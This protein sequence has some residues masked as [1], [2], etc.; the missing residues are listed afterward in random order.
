MKVGSKCGR[1]R[2]AIAWTL[3]LGVDIQKSLQEERRGREK[4]KE[5]VEGIVGRTGI[6]VVAYRSAERG[7]TYDT[8]KG[9]DGGWSQSSGLARA[10]DCAPSPESVSQRQAGTTTEWC[11]LVWSGMVWYCLVRYCVVRDG[12]A[13]YVSIA[14]RMVLQGGRF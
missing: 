10:W 7:V 6:C 11:G 5:R 2:C 4:R 13:W 9:W 8:A 12:I 3:R 14:V 1:G